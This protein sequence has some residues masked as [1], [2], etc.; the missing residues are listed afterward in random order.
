ME[1]LEGKVYDLM[2]WA[3]IEGIVYSEE[4]NPHSILGP[5][6]VEDGILIQKYVK[7]VF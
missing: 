6:V 5:K 4:N 1:T 3:A 7:I 2:D